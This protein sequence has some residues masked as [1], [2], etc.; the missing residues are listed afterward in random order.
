MNYIEVSNPPLLQFPKLC[1]KCYSKDVKPYQVGAKYRI[2]SFMHE[3]ILSVPLCI[4]CSDATKNAIKKR[5]Y[6]FLILS[7]NIIISFWVW[8]LFS[9]PFPMNLLIFEALMSISS[10]VYFLIA[11]KY[12]FVHNNIHLK[13]TSSDPNKM[14]V[15]KISLFNK[16]YVD[17]LRELNESILTDKRKVALGV[18][19][20]WEN[21]EQIN[22]EDD[23]DDEDDE[24]ENEELDEFELNLNA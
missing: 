24:S 4:D 10:I 18:I 12:E 22:L 13:A 17:I 1:V 20:I 6:F 7:L 16:A 19:E 14:P 2:R 9:I 5:N 8:N 3:I 11:R 23:V 21:V 15:L